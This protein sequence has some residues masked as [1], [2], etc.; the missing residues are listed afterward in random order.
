MRFYERILYLRGRS[1]WYLAFFPGLWVYN[2]TCGLSVSLLLPNL[3]GTLLFFFFVG[4]GLGGDEKQVFCIN[5]RNPNDL[6]HTIPCVIYRCGLIVVP[7]IFFP[8]FRNFSTRGYIS[9]HPSE[10]PISLL[11]PT[12]DRQCLSTALKE[13]TYQKSSGSRA[14]RLELP[15]MPSARPTSFYERCASFVGKFAVY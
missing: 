5:S 11:P 3:L 9:K 6:H 13:K 8:N 7:A 2:C 14:F 10:F 15:S 4:V 12:S 1:I